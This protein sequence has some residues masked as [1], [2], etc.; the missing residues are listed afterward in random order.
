V[1]RWG[2]GSETLHE[3]AS[4]VVV[5]MWDV[6]TGRARGTRARSG[7]DGPGTRPAR[8][9]AR[10][11]SPCRYVRSKWRRWLVASLS[12]ASLRGTGRGPSRISFSIW[13]SEACLVLLA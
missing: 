6:R 12:I 7:S 10:V 3:R 1:D 2:Q 11:S 5:G 13:R 8:G 9:G 4:E